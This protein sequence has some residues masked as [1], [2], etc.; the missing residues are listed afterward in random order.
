VTTNTREA[1]NDARLLI[2]CSTRS[3]DSSG[4]VLNENI[5]KSDNT[6]EI[7]DEGTTA[8]ELETIL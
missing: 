5:I 1:F 7:D 4:I 3:S 2:K 6:G 8:I